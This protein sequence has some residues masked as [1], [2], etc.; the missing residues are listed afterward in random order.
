MPSQLRCSSN[1]FGDLAPAHVRNSGWPP[2]RPNSE[3]DTSGVFSTPEKGWLGT[4]FAGHL[5]RR[6]A[7]CV[8]AFNSLPRRNATGSTPVQ[9]SSV[10]REG[11]GG[12]ESQ[13]SHKCDLGGHRPPLAHFRPI[14]RC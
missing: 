4:S 8:A 6:T 14:R 10:D 7:W 9:H 3:T 1:G 13:I 2:S 11:G 5:V 12:E